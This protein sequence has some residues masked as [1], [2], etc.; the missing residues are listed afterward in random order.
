[1]WKYNNISYGSVGCTAPT[2]T[3]GQIRTPTAV[4]GATV[5]DATSVD[6]T[7]DTG[8]TVGI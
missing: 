4:D 8:Y 1:M 3:T 5:T 7:C 2:L 6:Y